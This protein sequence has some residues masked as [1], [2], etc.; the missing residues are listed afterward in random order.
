MTL[1]GIAVLADPGSS[2][3]FLTLVLGTWLI[4]FGVLELVAALRVR[5][6]AGTSL[7][8]GEM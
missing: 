2:L 7:K 5:K 3:Y 4:F 1:A 8:E 6:L